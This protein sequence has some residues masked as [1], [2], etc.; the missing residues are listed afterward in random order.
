MAA[1]S[2]LGGQ[3]RDL[4]YRVDQSV[5]EIGRGP[6]DDRRAV[7]D[8]GGHRVQVSGEI[9]PCLHAD[10]GHIEIPRRLVERRVRGC[11]RHDLR[12][13]DPAPLACV[14]AVG[15]HRQHDALGAARADGAHDRRV[16]AG[17]LRA[18]HA[19]GHRHDLGLVLGR[20]RPQVGVERVGLRLRRVDPVEEGDVL[21]IAVVHRAGG[22]AVPPA[23]LLGPG[24]ALDQVLHLC[25]VQAVGWQLRVGGNIGP[26]A[27][28]LELV[29]QAGHELG[30]IHHPGPPWLAAAPTRAGS[31][32]DS[33][34]PASAAAARTPSEAYGLPITIWTISRSPPPPRFPA[35]S[36]NP[37]AA[38]ARSG[39]LCSSD[40]SSA[41]GSAAS[42]TNPSMNRT[43]PRKTS[44]CQAAIARN[45]TA[46]TLTVTWS[47]ARRLSRLAAAP[48]RIAAPMIPATVRIANR[49]PLAEPWWKW[50]RIGSS[51][52]ATALKMPIPTKSRPP[53][54][55]M[56]RSRFSQPS[57]TATDGSPRKAGGVRSASSTQ[58]AATTPSAP[59]TSSTSRRPPASN[60]GLP[61]RA[62]TR[63]PAYSDTLPME[64]AVV[65]SCSGKY[66]AATFVIELSTSGWPTAITSWPPHAHQNDPGLP[67]RSRPPAPVRTA[68]SPSARSKLTSSHLPNGSARM[69]YISGKMAAR[70]PTS[71]TDTPIARCVWA[72]MN[73]YDSQSS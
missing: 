49:T 72:S 24:E 47:I 25:P 41:T 26:A 56:K 40:Q 34:S 51:Q 57:E 45:A 10:Q 23:R 11:W 28:R 39:P 35:S 2:A 50:P 67:S 66:R 19:R 71:P 32:V 63:I 43:I 20:A 46:V 54:T 61:D 30:R 59:C 60:N 6:H 7:S 1:D 44:P 8:R 3:A 58:T 69:T 73:A 52:V 22:E 5:R 38:P 15:T 13:G 36:R 27:V 16:G 55:Q 70:S 17:V 68:P 48:G 4:R 9:C 31:L 29:F 14:I 42:S 21:G 12:R 18:Q 62:A 64:I 53:S 65:R 37:P 33:A